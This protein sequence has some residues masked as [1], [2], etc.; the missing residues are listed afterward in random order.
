LNELNYIESELLEVASHPD[1]A[2]EYYFGKKV[3]TENRFWDAILYFKNGFDALQN[4]WWSDQLNED[5]FKIFIECSF[6]I[7]YCYYELGLFDK[8]FKYLEFS[9]RNSRSGN[10]YQTE[11]INCL[12]ALKDIRALRIIDQNIE[13]LLKKDEA[14]RGEFDYDFQLFLIRRRCY[15]LIELKLFDQA[16]DGLKYLLQVD[17]ENQFAQQEL[18]YIKHLKSSQ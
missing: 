11:Y 7:G 3:M 10:K 12:I 6:S 5:E 17:P 18:E 13:V 8:S 15:C 1:I 14:E 16:E 9:V 2:K 4:K